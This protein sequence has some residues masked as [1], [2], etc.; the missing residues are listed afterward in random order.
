MVH[1][2][3]A[4]NSA[5]TAP[6]GVGAGGPA[7]VSVCRTLPT[8][9]DPTAGTFVAS[10]LAALAQLA[11]VR[12]VQP[13]PYFPIAKPLPSWAKAGERVHRGL[14]IEPAPM[15]Y[16]PGMLKF[17]D[18]WW[19]ARSARRS[20]EGLQRLRPVDL[21]DAHFGYPDGAGCVSVGRSL[22]LSVFVTIRGF[23]TEFLRTPGIGVQIVRS[24]NAATGVISVSHSLR[25]VAIEH[26]VDGDR[27]RVIPNAIDRA[28]FQPGS[29]E[30]ARRTLELD[31]DAPLVLSVGHLVVRK[32]HHVLVRAF[33][34][35]R[36]L[37]P[38]ATLAIIGAAVHERSY[39]EEL[40]RVVRDAG[41]GGHVRML[42]PLPQP[43][44]NTWLQACDVFALASHREGCCNAV[45]EA[46]A[47]GRPVVT[48][49]VGDNAHYVSAGVNGALVP[50]DDVAGLEHALATALGRSW[51]ARAIARTLEVGDW[52]AVAREV[53]SFF[54]ERLAEPTG[55][56]RTAHA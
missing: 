35:L 39:P 41:L 1:A 50:V 48:T 32:R 23:E 5:G 4:A 24:L 49:P 40:A 16:L 31:A 42:G 30:A 38:T 25:Q 13:V 21:I 9:A 54:R 29:R 15:L 27:V 19:L 2:P 56:S 37:Y 6:A 33:A 52:T 7:I 43:Q 17:L 34:G 12:V 28:V 53:L 10:R 51:D 46:L 45:L 55:V 36:R 3:S 20:I 44:V 11:D 14:A 22:G 47:A 8:P 26:G 18:A